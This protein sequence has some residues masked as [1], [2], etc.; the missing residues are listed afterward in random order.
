MKLY[1]WEDTRLGSGSD[2]GGTLGAIATSA[3]EA[4]QKIRAHFSENHSKY[5]YDMDRIIC[6]DGSTLNDWLE[7]DLAK[8]PTTAEVFLAF[9]GDL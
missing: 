8:E 9:G 7:S 1:I 6:S 3:S 5:G 2:F 4:R